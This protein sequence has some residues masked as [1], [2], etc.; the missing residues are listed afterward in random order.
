MN[1]WTILGTRATSDEREIKRAY[2]RRL[3]VTRPEDDP[4]GFQAL[5]DA[6]EA[7]LNMARNAAAQEDGDADTEVH[8]ESV[9]TATYRDE[10]HT[11]SGQVYT[12]AYEFDP[13]QPNAVSPSN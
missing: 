5:R 1:L 12:A 8:Q 4:E 3:K 13:A 9:Y 10:Q 2:A 11:S 7:A 6:Y